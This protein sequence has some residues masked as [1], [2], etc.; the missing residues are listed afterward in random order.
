MGIGKD[1]AYIVSVIRNLAMDKIKRGIG[2]NLYNSS[3]ESK[4]LAHDLIIFFLDSN[5]KE[6]AQNFFKG[7]E[8]GFIDIKG[9]PISLID[10]VAYKDID[11]LAN[12]RAHLEYYSRGASLI[13]FKVGRKSQSRIITDKEDVLPT[14]LKSIQEESVNRIERKNKK[15]EKTTQ[16]DYPNTLRMGKDY[17]TGEGLLLFVAKRD[18][19]LVI[20]TFPSVQDL[21]DYLYKR[22][23]DGKYA[24]LPKVL[25]T[26]KEARKVRPLRE[27]E[28]LYRNGFDYR[29]GA[30]VSPEEFHDFF[31]FK[32]I[33]F[34]KYVNNALRQENLNESFDA[35]NDMCL[36][37]NVSRETL[38]TPLADRRFSLAFGARGKGGR[39]ASGYSTLAHFENG[40]FIMNLAKRTNSNMGGAG[41]LAHEFFH[42]ID[43]EIGG[44]TAFYSAQSIMK[45]EGGGE[46]VTASPKTD[47]HREALKH[48]DSIMRKLFDSEMYRESKEEDKKSA[49]D[50]FS[51][52]EEMFARGAEKVIQ[53]IL[54]EK[55]QIENKFLVS[56]VDN[57]PLFPDE[58][59]AKSL[60]VDFENLFSCLSKHRI[61]LGIDNKEDVGFS[62]PEFSRKSVSK[63]ANI[64]DDF[65]KTPLP[66]KKSIKKIKRPT[67]F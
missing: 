50:Y 31:P 49:N 38:M 40:Y 53:L 62:P 43:A 54:R 4:E 37:M 67:L 29:D 66:E 18:K 58:E 1:T 22:D 8:E 19:R 55:H 24:N 42:G 23:A 21:K 10:E 13:E 20:D 15:K 41:K 61:E 5:S 12:S 39:N 28:H 48:F 16:E 14:L 59:L 57:S 65:E 26:L 44:G 45:M 51:L 52:P 7:V 47:A 33:Q 32:G 34:G 46:F 2:R 25:E 30:N 27:N 60:R 3:L 11:L 9:L 35:L 63:Y 6:Q 56:Y 17:K 64:D 36:A